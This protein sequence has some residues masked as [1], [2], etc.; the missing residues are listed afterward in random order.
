MCFCYKSIIWEEK[1]YSLVLSCAYGLLK[2]EEK[3]KISHIFIPTSSIPSIQIKQALEYSCTFNPL[4]VLHCAFLTSDSLDISRHL[5]S[6]IFFIVRDYVDRCSSLP[7]TLTTSAL[8]RVLLTQDITPS[9]I[10]SSNISRA[11]LASP[12]CSLLVLLLPCCKT[13]ARRSNGRAQLQQVALLAPAS[14]PSVLRRPLL[15]FALPRR[16]PAHGV[17]RRLAVCPRSARWSTSARLRTLDSSSR[18]C[19]G[20]S[21]LSFSR[22][23]PLHNLGKRPHRHWVLLRW[24]W[25]PSSTTPVLRRRVHVSGSRYG[26]LKK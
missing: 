4:D 14:A 24:C 17:C 12:L 21:S 8:P 19:L 22:Q 20:S 2:K 10:S 26:V 3:N 6:L 9:V 11:W 7:Q 13:I 18:I 23:G 16:A 25:T 15:Q 1:S 5:F